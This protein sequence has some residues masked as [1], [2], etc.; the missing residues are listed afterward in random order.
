MT[1][2]KNNIRGIWNV[3]NSVTKNEPRQ[4]YP[5]YF[6][7]NNKKNY[8]IN[9]VVNSN[10]FFVNVGPDLA[11]KIHLQKTSD[12]WT[13]LPVKINPYTMFLTPVDEK[14]ILDIVNKCNNKKSTDL[15]E[16]DMTL[17]KKIIHSISKPLTYILICHFKQAYFPKKLKLQRLFP[18]I[19]LGTKITL[20]IIDEFLFC[21]SFQKSWKNYTIV[22]WK[23]VL[24][25]L[26][27]Y[28]TVSTD[29][30]RTGLHHMQ[31]QKQ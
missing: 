28:Q 18:Y 9:E 3:I 12:K 23:N 15:N 26:I 11:A 22:D 19:K 4:T 13:E 17:V 2:N 8:N 10:H 31:Y 24:E 27:Y 29:S 5:E 16:I 20:Q 1:N 25:N 21:H 30:E 6:N 14:E 7:V